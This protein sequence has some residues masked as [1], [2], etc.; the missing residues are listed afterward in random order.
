VPKHPELQWPEAWW[1][2]LLEAFA[3]Q[4]FAHENKDKVLKTD[5][6]SREAPPNVTVLKDP[7]RAVNS[8]S[9]SLLFIFK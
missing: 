8:S 4:P 6:S 3:K 1:W 2:P 9:E 5:D 7:C